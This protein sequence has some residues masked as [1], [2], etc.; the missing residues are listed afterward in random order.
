MENYYQD[1]LANETNSGNNTDQKSFQSD[2]K[3]ST[4]ESVCGPEKWKGQIEKVVP[5]VVFR[6]LYY[7]LQQLLLPFCLVLLV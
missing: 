5:C 2:S 1:L 7:F 3:S 6:I 4:T